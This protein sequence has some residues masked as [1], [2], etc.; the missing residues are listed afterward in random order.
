LT[1]HKILTPE[2]T[3][4]SLKRLIRKDW[5][6]VLRRAEQVRQN[7]SA[8]G[9]RFC[10]R[11]QGLPSLTSPYWHELAGALHGACP[12]ASQAPR[13]F[14]VGRSLGMSSPPSSPQQVVL[15]GPIYQHLLRR[16]PKMTP[17]GSASTTFPRS[18]VLLGAEAQVPGASPVPPRSSSPPPPT[19]EQETSAWGKE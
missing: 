12:D 13:T 15:C 6:W 18:L 1:K 16:G 19:Q 2:K 5:E 3:G 14:W 4:F 7:S 11:E 8:S 10:A 9:G 17:H